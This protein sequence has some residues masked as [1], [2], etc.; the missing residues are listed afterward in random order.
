MPRILLQLL[1]VFLP[2]HAFLV[3]LSSKYLFG[4]NQDALPIANFIVA[5]WK[6]GILFL[7]LCFG[8][9]HIRKF[10]WKQIDSW[11]FFFIALHLAYAIVQ[12]FTHTTPFTQIIWGLRSNLEMLGAFWIIRLFNFTSKEI[13]TFIKILLISTTISLLFGIFQLVVPCETLQIFGYSPYVSSWVADKPLPCGHGVGE[14]LDTLRMM[15]TFSSPN[16]LASFLILSLG[17]L[18]YSW[19]QKLFSQWMLIP[20]F[21]LNI[22]S[23][24]LTF[25]RG[26]WL[27]SIIAAGFLIFASFQH[28]SKKMLLW[29]GSAVLVGIIVL[30]LLV[31]LSPARSGSTLEHFQ[32]PIAGIERVIERPWGYGVGMAGPI[33]L[34]FPP[35]GSQAKVSENWYIQIAEEVGAFGLAIAFVFLISIF[36]LLWKEKKNH[37]SITLLFTF[38]AISINAVFLHTWTNDTATS[39]VFWMFLGLMIQNQIIEEKV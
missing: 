36:L 17:L 1:L 12:Y 3:T 5:S 26:A 15:G 4:G 2:F 21:L 24:I 13:H 19:K 33:S 32:K 23:L 20:A 38:I 25:S 28:R 18:W 29:I 8:I 14:S 7:L 31:F 22:G 9:Q 6:E 35:D 11:I 30:G 16:A 37:L 34:R 10:Q 27:G 39:L